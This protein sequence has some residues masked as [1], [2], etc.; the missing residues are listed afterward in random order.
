MNDRATLHDQPMIISVA[1]NGARRSQ[2]D[3]P[4]L[5]ITPAELARTASECAEQGASLIHLHVRDA[6]GRHSLDV[7]AYRAALGA[8]RKAVGD[9]LVLQ[10]TSEAAG[11]YK[12][13]EQMAAIYALQPEAVSISPREIIPDASH[14]SAAAEFLSWL[15]TTGSFPQFIL[16]SAKELIWFNELIERGIVPF[17]RPQVLFVLGRYSLDGLSEPADLLPFLVVNKGKLPW[18][19]CAFGRQEAAC[20]VVAAGFGGHVRVGFENN[21]HLPDGTTAPSNG[22][23]IQAVKSGLPSL[24]RAV[25]DVETTRRDFAECSV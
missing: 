21:L 4:A 17:K 8:V 10:V 2:K 19:M 9:R 14:E 12:A 24:G 22:A 25:A 1:P 13:H 23:L 6:N 16:Y 20:A 3:H 5:P 7:D 11:C 15:R 18:S